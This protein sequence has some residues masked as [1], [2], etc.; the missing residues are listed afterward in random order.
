MW[1]GF[2]L[3]TAALAFAFAMHTR[4]QSRW[5]GMPSRVAAVAYDYQRVAS[6]KKIVK[7]RVGVSAPKALHF[8]IRREGKRDAFF[9]WLGVSDEMQTKDAAFDERLYLESDAVAIRYVIRSQ[10]SLRASILQLFDTAEALDGKGIQL[11]CANGRLWL[12]FKPG[13]QNV[14]DTAPQQLAPTL[15]SITT[16]LQRHRLDETNARDPFVW[17]AAALLAFSTAMAV[18]GGL[19]LVRGSIGR[20]DILDPWQLLLACVPIGL[21]LAAGFLLFVLVVLGRSSR[22]HVVLLEAALVGSFGFVAGSFALAREANIE[23]DTSKPESHLLADAKVEHRITRGRRG[24]RNHHY[25]LHA[26]DWRPEHQGA[27]R[28]ME[29]DSST[30]QRLR[31][32]N[33]AVIVT[34]RGALGYEWVESMTAP[35]PTGEAGRAEYP[36]STY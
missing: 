24:R 15:H 36:S 11:R 4:L 6:K 8:R 7:V 22:T 32:N 31:D 13:S 20:T 14:L 17:R 27:Y 28:S 35:D 10:P 3:I 21:I 33:G 29:I 34:R 30:F 26:S 16:E 25:Y 19:G 12:E 5:K 9:K 1:F 2:G 23:L 18:L